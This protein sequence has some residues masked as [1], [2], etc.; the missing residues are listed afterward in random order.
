MKGP[1]S[2]AWGGGPYGVFSRHHRFSQQLEQPDEVADRRREGEGHVDAL[3]LSHPVAQRLPIAGATDHGRDRCDRGPSRGMLALVVSRWCGRHGMRGFASSWLH[4]L[5]IWS[6]RNPGPVHYRTAA[7]GCSACSATST[8]SPG[9]NSASTSA[10]IFDGRP[11]T[12]RMIT[13]LGWLSTPRTSCDFT[14]PV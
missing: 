14:M 6:L 5:K 3:R 11:S 13:I 8:V 10:L 7:T 12:I 2:E 4:S 9:C 1:S